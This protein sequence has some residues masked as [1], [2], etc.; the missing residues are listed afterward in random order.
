MSTR[1]IVD[2]I[3]IPCFAD[4]KE[5]LAFAEKLLKK[6]RVPFDKESIH[7]HKK[8][9]DARRKQNIT[10][11]CSVTAKSDADLSSRESIAGIRF[12]PEEELTFGCGTEKMNGRPF[13]I[14]FGPAGIFCGLV[15][16]AH[17]LRPVILERGSAV[18]ERV[19]KIDSF[20]K[21]GVLDTET[22]IQFGAGG[23][24]T[25][26]DGK[27]VT[28]IGD[29][30]TS[31]VLEKLHE[32]GAPESILWNAKPHVGTDILRTVVSRASEEIQALGGEIRYNTK[33]ETVG[34]GYVIV[35]GEKIPCGV[36]VLAPGHSS[37]DTY[38]NLLSAGY[39]VEAKPFSIGVR[40][41]HLQ[42]ELDRAMYGDE[43]FSERLGHA[44]YQL[45]L[46]NGDRGVYT[47]CMCP[48]GEVMAAA[49][50][51]GGVVTN[52]MSHHARDG[53]NANAA[54][55]VSV[56]P[57]DFSG[58]P[59]GAIEF[60]RRLEK[61]A[62]AA[63]GGGYCAP[64]QSVGAFFDGKEGGYGNII[65]PSYMNSNVRGADFNKLLPEFASSMLKEGLRAFGKKI[66]GYDNPIVPLTGIE[67]RTSAP[68]RILRDER[69]L[70]LGHEY[71]YPCGEG[72]G[73]AGGITSAAVDG[74]RVAEA[75]LSRFR[76][77]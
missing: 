57:S 69:F 40:A 28:R 27:L 25:F 65:V 32:L 67:T 15:L 24:G 1:I 73:Y 49:S 7:I 50:E 3:R 72:A 74:I 30:R 76:R 47:F 55:A 64:C 70:A 18:E 71:V 5:A 51:E 66:K 16:A 36:V 68:I 10:F 21:T 17:G 59:M 14:G 42:V 53:V 13:I 19:S 2:N 46:R 63:G 54:V 29:S 41:E 11:V 77:N 48:G 23:A 4:E 33:A 75:I 8:S 45:S 38:A 31:F 26:S 62:Y 37:R 6:N 39:A 22:N 58:D 56:L 61:A 12:L 60:Q 9:V 34:D 52:G 35:D 20:Y 43:C 44:E